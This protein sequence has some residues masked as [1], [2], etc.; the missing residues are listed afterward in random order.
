M[1]HNGRIF[2]SEAQV[3]AVLVAAN[4]ALG[5]GEVE[6]YL[7][8]DSPA[9]GGVQAAVMTLIRA[10][11]VEARNGTQGPT[12]YFCFRRDEVLRFLRRE[13]PGELPASL[14]R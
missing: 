3:L 13:Y 12:T 7:P 1:N 11:L 14:R 6:A 10:G 9:R 5:V 4:C 2:L 8:D